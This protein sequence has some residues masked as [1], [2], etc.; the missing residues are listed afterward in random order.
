MNMLKKIIKDRMEYA[1]F[2]MW[3]MQELKNER[4][5]D[6]YFTEFSCLRQ[7]LVEYGIKNNY[8]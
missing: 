2:Q 6:I 3:R 5:E 7:I 8:M 4:M 1:L